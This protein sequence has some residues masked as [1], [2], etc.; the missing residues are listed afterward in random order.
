MLIP[1][2]DYERYRIIMES[3]F[4]FEGQDYLY[5]PE[6]QNYYTLYRTK[7]KINSF[8]ELEYVAEKFLYLNP[9]FD[10]DL[11]KRL[12]VQLSDRDSGHIIRSYG[13]SRVKAMIDRVYDKKTAPY[14][15]RK[16]KVVFNPSKKISRSDKMKI[17]AKLV[18]RKKRPHTDDIDAVIE[19]LWLSKEKITASKIA[20]RLNTTRHLVK[21]YF[22][23][24][25]TSAIKKINQEIR[26]E[27]LVS[28]A[29]EAID[30]L[31]DKG[32]KL[33][34]RRLKE[35]TSIRDYNLLKE[36]VVKYQ[37]QL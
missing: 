27:N 18:N 29:I 35:L 16:R 33:K 7:R 34:M 13:E 30:V 25:K 20:D 5:F 31:T 17:V 23:E 22:D 6:G 2:F 26:Y 11:T 32:N 24:E 15:P 1:L 14:C 4:K 19:E 12:F 10:I 3:Y 21:F 37:D 28:R 36:A 8:S 9:A